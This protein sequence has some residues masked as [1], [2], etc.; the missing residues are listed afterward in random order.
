MT[1]LRQ[2]FQDRGK[3][4]RQVFADLPNPAHRAV[5]WHIGYQ[6]I[7]WRYRGGVVSD[8]DLMARARVTKD[9]VKRA[10]RAAESRGHIKVSWNGIV[11]WVGPI[12][13]A[14]AQLPPATFV[15]VGPPNDPPF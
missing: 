3:W 12:I 8:R 14:E 2:S 15:H 9:M 1:S 10:L 4:I 5:M 13:K 6:F 7:D 11:R